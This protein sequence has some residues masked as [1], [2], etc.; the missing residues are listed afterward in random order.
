MA[1]VQRT[2]R[3]TRLA[4]PRPASAP[5]C[6]STTSAARTTEPTPLHAQPA[7]PGLPCSTPGSADPSPATVRASPVPCSRHLWFAVLL[8]AYAA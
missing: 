6:R 3:A 1:C 7:V 5:A 8:A 4:R 2:R